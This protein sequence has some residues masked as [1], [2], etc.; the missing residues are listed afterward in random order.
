MKRAIDKSLLSAFDTIKDD[1]EEILWVGKPKFIPY[2]ITGIGMGIGIF[3]FVAIYYGMA[4]DEGNSDG[5]GNFS[6]WFIGLPVI[7]FLYEFGK[8]LLSY[9]NTRYADSNRRIMIR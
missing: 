7:F 2:A 1:K 3:I 5:S 9:G 6:F 4:K 8:K